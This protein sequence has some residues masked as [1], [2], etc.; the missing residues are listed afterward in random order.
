V[1][2]R[3]VVTTLGFVDPEYGV[4]GRLTEKSDVFSY[5]M[6]LLV[7]VS[8]RRM[9][10][11]QPSGSKRFV[12]TGCRWTWRL[13]LEFCCGC[14]GLNYLVIF[15]GRQTAAAHMDATLSDSGAV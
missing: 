5:G 13:G 4:T 14:D 9:L 2:Q 7:L 11:S 12:C 10:E 15:H 1:S 3:A 8:G 6:L